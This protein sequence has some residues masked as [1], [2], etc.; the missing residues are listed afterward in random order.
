[1]ERSQVAQLLAQHRT[2]LR[3]EF[4]VTRLA[5]IG[6]TLRDEAMGCRNHAARATRTAPR[7]RRQRRVR[8]PPA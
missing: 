6:S 5:L 1:M 8:P 2:C 4:G 3:R 7:V